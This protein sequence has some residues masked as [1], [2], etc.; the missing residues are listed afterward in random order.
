MNELTARVTLCAWKRSKNERSCSKG[1]VAGSLK[2][3]GS[4]L[5]IGVPLERSKKIKKIIDDLV[6]ILNLATTSADASRYRCTVMAAGLTNRQ[7]RLLQM[8]R[9]SWPSHKTLGD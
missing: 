4:P 6:A 5:R 8:E 1:G 2:R 9:S 3:A 7:S